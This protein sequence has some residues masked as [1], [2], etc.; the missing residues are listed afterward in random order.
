MSWAERDLLHFCKI[1]LWVPVQSQF[2][3]RNQW[4]LRMWPDLKNVDKNFHLNSFPLT[5]LQ[6]L[7][8]VSFLYREDIETTVAYTGFPVCLSTN[9]F[10]K[11]SQKSVDN[12]CQ[13]MRVCTTFERT[14]NLK[15]EREFI[16]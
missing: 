1:I 13:E 11:V 16:K 14:G 15:T 9:N 12:Q 5:K 3:N 7:S 10:N 2:A 8:F 6:N 4:V